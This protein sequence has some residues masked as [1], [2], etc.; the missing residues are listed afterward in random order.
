[1]NHGQTFKTANYLNHIYCDYLLKL[2]W[3]VW[4]EAWCWTQCQ[5]A[6]P[7]ICHRAPV[8]FVVTRHT[9][10]VTLHH[11]EGVMGPHAGQ[12]D[13]LHTGLATVGRSAA[14]HIQRR[15]L[16]T[17]LLPSPGLPTTP[18]VF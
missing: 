18:E 15:L 17:A 16:S 7:H 8:A 12:V 4:S 2:T 13:A 9:P 6:G 11:L 10:V 3:M 5:G 1:M 14:G